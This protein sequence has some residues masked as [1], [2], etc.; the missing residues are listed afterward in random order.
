[1]DAFLVAI[2][3]GMSPIF[4]LNAFVASNTDNINFERASE[5]ISSGIYTTKNIG[6]VL[7][8]DMAWEL[9]DLGMTLTADAVDYKYTVENVAKSYD[10]GHFI[11]IPDDRLAVEISKLQHTAGWAAFREY[12]KKQLAG[13]MDKLTPYILDSMVQKYKTEQSMNALSDKVM[14]EYEHFIADIKTKSPD[15]IVAAAYEIVQKDNIADMFN[16][17]APELSKE[18]IDI[19]RESDN[20]LDRIYKSY[21]ELTREHGFVELETAVEDAAQGL[22]MEKAEQQ[23]LQELAAKQQKPISINKPTPNMNTISNQQAKPMKH[24]GR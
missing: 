14:G 11:K 1:M 22:R 15:E 18:D 9:H 17:S 24:K 2:R 19:L 3:R 6:M 4:A 13:E 21:F 23:R 20:A 8:Q 16:F 12:L 7:T 5:L 10:F